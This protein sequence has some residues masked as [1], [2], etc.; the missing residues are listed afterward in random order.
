MALGAH[1]KLIKGFIKKD[2]RLDERIW[3]EEGKVHEN[4]YPTFADRFDTCLGACQ[5]QTLRGY[6]DSKGSI[7]EALLRCTIRHP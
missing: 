1:G 3:A 5:Q 2:A 4:G 7:G 6:D